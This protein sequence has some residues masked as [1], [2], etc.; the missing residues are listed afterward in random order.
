M[1]GAVEERTQGGHRRVAI[2]R[3]SV[4]EKAQEFRFECFR[5]GP[6]TTVRGVKG[7]PPCVRGLGQ[8]RTQRGGR[9]SRQGL[10]ARRRHGRDRLGRVSAARPWIGGPG[11]AGL[12]GHVGKTRPAPFFRRRQITGAFVGLQLGRQPEMRR[13][14]VGLLDRLQVEPHAG[15][16]IGMLLAVHQHADE[17]LVEIGRRFRVGEGLLASGAAEFTQRRAHEEVNRLFLRLGPP[18][19][20]RVP[21][22]P[23]DRTVRLRADKGRR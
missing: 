7:G 6:E 12:V 13:P 14:A 16:D 17:M 23:V 18:Q 19:D 5:R 10:C 20:V 9:E 2:G 8:F 11:L 22:F 15:G 4:Q 3:G 1:G 21:R